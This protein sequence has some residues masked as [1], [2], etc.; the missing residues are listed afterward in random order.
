MGLTMECAQCHDH[1]YDP[2]SQ[3]EYYRF[4]AYFNNHTDPGMQTRRGNQAP[5][6]HVVPPAD[7][8]R[9]EV[10][11]ADL[12]KAEDMRA[13]A[14]R[15]G[16][17]ALGEW[18]KQAGEKEMPEPKEM[19]HFFAL[20][21]GKRD[22]AVDLVSAK[23][24]VFEGP[25]TCA[26]VEPGERRGMEF[27]GRT[28][29]TFNDFPD[30]D[31]KNKAFTLSAWLKVPKGTSGAV[32]SDMDVD[33]NHRGWDLWLQGSRVGTHIVS[34]WPKNAVKVV[35]KEALPP[36]TWH[37]VAVTYDGKGEAGGV[38]IYIDGKVAD[39]VVEQ[40]KL[41]GSTKSGAPFR[42]GARSTDAHFKGAVDDIRIYGRVLTEEEVAQ[43]A[44]NPVEVALS[45]PAEKRSP[46]QTKLLEEYFY[47]TEQEHYRA[48][49]AVT[50]RARHEEKLLT[51]GKA[52]TMIMAD[53]PPE[54]IRMTYMLN[55][56]AYD[57]PVKDE[58]ITAGV[59]S[60]LP[61]VDAE[62]PPNR[63]TVARWL[64]TEEHPLTARVAVNMIWQEFF[65]VGLVETPGDFGAQGAYPSHPEL[66][67][68]LAVDFRENGWDV[69]R[70]IRQIVTSR[71]Y[72]QASTVRP[73]HLARDPG[74]RLLARAPRFRLHA[75]FVRDNALAISG[76]LNREIGGPGVKPYQPPGLWAQV[77]LG[78]NPKFVQDKGEKLYRRSIYTY[79]KRSAPAPGLQI[80]DAPTREVCT[81]KRPRTNTPLQA[82][83]TLNDTQFVEAARMLAERMLKD[84]GD[85]GDAR[86]AFAFE[87]ATA[88]PPNDAELSTMR[89]I[90]RKALA[91]YEAAPDLAA[92]LLAVGEAKRDEALPAV[93]HA[94][95]TI[96]AS[97]ILNL[98][99]TLTRE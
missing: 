63:L 87:L 65:G 10:V 97:L 95:A 6:V 11:R 73:E 57:Q 29:V 23:V 90:H 49:L 17:E 38:T 13:Q 45:T 66:L 75:E 78:G 86:H 44:E 72:R 52:T 88:R 92:K 71:T 64:F 70:L 34:S 9:L 51:K 59:P 60:V 8:E 16:R 48:A 20:D 77:G 19:K 26:V 4:Y 5:V 98:D 1:K 83:V 7:G 37:H 36:G 61:P 67:D 74:N 3:R 28:A 43:A 22:I 91:K 81:M 69:K 85:A 46:Q 47:T 15:E 18:L 21:G 79:F 31:F 56:G 39:N 94:A 80:F 35:S 50:S 42:I 53:N 93:E 30:Y 84:G 24:G 33:K 40:A 99:E 89:Q 82:L 58:V 14:R 12:K 32:I 27:D 25:G 41:T 68:W 54:K 55:R 96:V 62:A 76:L 2:I